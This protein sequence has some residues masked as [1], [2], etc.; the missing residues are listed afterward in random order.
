MC[1]NWTIE[2]GK[3]QKE[4]TTFA[5]QDVTQDN[6]VSIDK[7]LNSHSTSALS[8]PRLRAI[9]VFSAFVVELQKRVLRCLLT[10]REYKSDLKEIHIYYFINSYK[11]STIRQKG[12]FYNTKL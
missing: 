11:T 5:Q 4:R 1:E 10:I 6:P 9:T 7:V 2:N 3:T 8:N 12:Y